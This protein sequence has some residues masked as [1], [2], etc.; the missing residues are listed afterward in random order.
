MATAATLTA[1]STLPSSPYFKVH[2]YFN[3]KQA[4]APVRQSVAPP[5]SAP[6]S[7]LD[8]A[9]VDRSAVV[10]FP[11]AVG[12]FPVASTAVTNDAVDWAFLSLNRPP[13]LSQAYM[14]RPE[15]EALAVAAAG[16]SARATVV[17]ADGNRLLLQLPGH[18]DV[19]LLVYTADPYNPSLDRLPICH[20]RRRSA[21]PLDTGLLSRSK[22]YA[23][24][25]MH[26]LHEYDGP[27]VVVNVY[28]STVGDWVV[29]VLDPPAGIPS[30]SGTISSSAG[31]DESPP[32]RPWRHPS[33]AE[34]SGL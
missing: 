28:S 25:F 5:T 10:V 27:Y 11:E 3:T 17:A 12:L 24:A 2:P 4:A 9:L 33:L 29:R 6:Q 30:P 14:V 34:P 15:A 18:P 23:I 20:A 32:S 19:R 31:T 26:R 21:L 8:W 13:F 7:L 22:D 1:F 16:G